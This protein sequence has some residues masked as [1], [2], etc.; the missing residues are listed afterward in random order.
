M[1]GVIG[2]FME[3]SKELSFNAGQTESVCMDERASRNEFT[4]EMAKMALLLL[5]AL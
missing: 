3:I 1:L 4:V 5:G 2:I